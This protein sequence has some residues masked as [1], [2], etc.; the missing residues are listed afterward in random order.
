MLFRNGT[1][2]VDAVCFFAEA[3]PV[4]VIAAHERGFEEYGTAYRGQGG[5][6]PALDPA[7][8]V[9]VEFANGVRGVLNCA[10]LTPAIFEF[11]LQG[12]SGRYRLTDSGG[13]AWKTDQPE[14]ESRAVPVPWTSLSAEHFGENLVPAVQEL[15]HMVW[16][17][18]P[19]SSPPRR[20]RH[21]LEILL[22]ALLSQVR[23]SA[24]IQLLPRRSID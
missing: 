7:S 12:L 13:A 20:A 1:H 11:D 23:G 18:V 5:K 8:T 9:I 21:T 4:W 3:A 6:D 24:K 22:A 19:S 14:G 2:L 17:D 16:H 10:K 15:A